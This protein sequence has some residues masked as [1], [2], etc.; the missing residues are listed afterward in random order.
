MTSTSRD[1]FEL[2]ALQRVAQS[3]ARALE[4]DVVLRRCLEQSMKVAEADFGVI[5]LDDARRK[6]LR[7]AVAMPDPE[8]GPPTLD[9]RVIDEKIVDTFSMWDLDDPTRVAATPGI[10]RGRARGIRRAYVLRFIVDERRVGFL[11]LLFKTAHELAP[12]TRDTLLAMGGFEAAAIEAARVHR[13]LAD[14]ARVAN[15]LRHFGEQALDRDADVPRLILD[16]ACAVANVDRATILQMIDQDDG[17]RIARVTGVIGSGQEV[18][19]GLELPETSRYIAEALAEMRVVEDLG[20]HD[21]DAVEVRLCRQIGVESYIVVPMRKR[22]RAVGL[23]VA[24]HGEKRAFG[25]GEIEG[26]ALFSTMAAA[27][28]ERDRRQQEERA[29]HL[30]LAAV[31]EH[32]PIVVAVIEKSGAISHINRAGREFAK[33]TG[34]DGRNWQTGA[35]A[36]T[37]YDREGNVMPPEK[38]QIL[39]AFAGHSPPP[40]ELT[41]AMGEHRIPVLSV[42]APLPEPDGSVR[43]VVTAFQD[44]SLL[45]KLADA[46]D[47]FLSIASHELRSPITSLRATTSL[48]QMDPASLTDESRRTVLFHRIQRQ[49]DR[50][51]TLVERLLDTARLNAGELP[52]DVANCELNALTGEALELCKPTLGAHTVVFEPGP[53]L[54]GCWDAARIEQVVTNLVSNAARYSP[55]GEIR[56]RLRSDGNMACVDVIDRGVGIPPEELPNI[57][58][59]FFRGARA[60]TQHKQGLGLGLFIS[61]EI[62]RRHGGKLEVQSEPGHGS[63]FTV[64]LPLAAVGLPPAQK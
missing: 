13:E 14:R 57:F 48:L 1:A 2:V 32:L 11:T 44:V 63:T 35:R 54:V 40:L 51:A 15:L 46:K 52:L 30:R 60:A 22:D 12:S 26:M 56:V 3:G 50:L 59:P 27:A 43:S 62:A 9:A 55:P 5:Y 53:P 58:T 31:I 18:L 10:E 37:V 28:L 49:I 25:E 24:G 21:P 20:G 39:E 45:R 42:V 7:R 41:L 33:I 38:S 34:G 23:L 64:A 8:L 17:T 61:S 6:V 47:R 16:T 19:R 4:L 36:V 29:Q